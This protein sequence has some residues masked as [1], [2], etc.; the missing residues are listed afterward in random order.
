MRED[1]DAQQ[2]TSDTP[3]ADG[4]GETGHPGNHSS[5]SE[6]YGDADFD[7]TYDDSYDEDTADDGTTGSGD[8]DTTEPTGS[9][10]GADPPYGDDEVVIYDETDDTTGDTT[11]DETTGDEVT[12]EGD[13]GG[14]YGDGETDDEVVIYDE[15]DEAGEV[16]D[17]DG[18][19]AGVD[20]GTSL[21]DGDVLAQDASPL[22]GIGYLL[23][24]VRD[25]LLGDDDTAG[26]AFETDP[27]D[28]ASGSD[29]DLTGDGAVDAADLHE[30]GSAFDFDVDDTTHGGH[31][32]GVIDA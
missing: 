18:P 7:D 2:G 26:P 3:L 6:P 4:L 13:D 21:D 29:L 24:E 30:A 32:E 8:T 23:D 25:A 11:D 17:T 1:D 20:D 27:A 12:D 15:T 16:D 5:T 10:D 28:L 31:D 22:E 14:G 19:D 9:D